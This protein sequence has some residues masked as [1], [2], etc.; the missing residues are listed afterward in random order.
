MLHRLRLTTQHNLLSIQ[1]RFRQSM[2]VM[3]THLAS[4]YW[5]GQT[6]YGPFMTNIGWAMAYGAPSHVINTKTQ[7]M[8]TWGK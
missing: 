5:V 3:G 1:T 6:Y 2:T 4:K 8:K 7:I